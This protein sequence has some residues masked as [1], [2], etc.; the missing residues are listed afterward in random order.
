MPKPC[1]KRDIPPW[2]L[3]FEA[4]AEMVLP[5]VGDGSI[6]AVVASNCPLAVAEAAVPAAILLVL[7]VDVPEKREKGL[8]GRP[9]VV[10]GRRDGVDGR[11]KS[12]VV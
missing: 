8:F 6:A 10:R 3:T 11:M 4:R 12:G 9:L 1:N 5:Q 7:P 2:L